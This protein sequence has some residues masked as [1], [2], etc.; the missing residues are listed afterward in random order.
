METNLLFSTKLCKKCCAQGVCRYS[1]L[2]LPN[3][4]SFYHLNITLYAAKPSE[5][6][7]WIYIWLLVVYVAQMVGI[8]LVSNDFHIC[9]YTNKMYALNALLH[10]SKMH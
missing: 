7:C 5:V 2:Q 9:T 8:V 6:C 1:I 3:T 4:V 10:N